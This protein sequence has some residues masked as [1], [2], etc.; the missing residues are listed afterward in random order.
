MSL[1]LVPQFALKVVFPHSWWRA[2]EGK[3]HWPKRTLM[4]ID[5]RLST[6][7]YV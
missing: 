1:F 3:L 2:D 7:A 5:C 6:E 4:T